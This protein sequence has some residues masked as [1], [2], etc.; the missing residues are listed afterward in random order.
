MNLKGISI[1]LPVTDEK[2]VVVKK[3]RK[4]G[5]KNKIDSYCYFDDDAELLLKAGVSELVSPLKVTGMSL[6]RIVTRT[7]E[8]NAIEQDKTIKG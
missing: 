3:L 6:G 5:Y 8:S 1:C 7:E 2:V 4:L